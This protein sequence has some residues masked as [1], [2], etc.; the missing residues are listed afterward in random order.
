MCFYKVYYK[1]AKQM[2]GAM[3]WYTII[4][5][6]FLPLLTNIKSWL[7]VGTWISIDWLMWWRENRLQGACCCHAWKTIHS[8][9]AH[10]CWT[11][12]LSGNE[13]YLCQLNKRRSQ[14]P[15]SVWNIKNVVHVCVCVHV[16]AWAYTYTYVVYLYKGILV[17]VVTLVVRNTVS[18]HRTGQGWMHHLN[19]F[20]NHC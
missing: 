4:T 14:D 3:K 18:A 20:I 10:T 12:L 5:F 17:W 19:M 7:F 16:L 9:G 8:Y 13:P 6:F 11:Q 2:T 15:G 1:S